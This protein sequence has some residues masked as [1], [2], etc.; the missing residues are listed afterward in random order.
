M[1][2]EPGGEVT[3]LLE[4]WREGQ[5]EAL[6]E[7]LPLVYEELR[8]LAAHY[9]G[10]ER[11]G[12]TLQATALVHEAYVRL[13]GKPLQ[14]EDRSHFFAVAARAMRRVLV[15]HARRHQADKRIGPQDKVSLE[16][17]PELSVQPDV[18]VL[19]LH[20]ALERLGQVN[21]RQAKLVEIRYFGGLKNRE[22]AE[23]LGVSL[24]TVERDWQVARL[25]LHRQLTGD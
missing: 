1:A 20:E 6:D 18:D 11:R 12:H 15:D 19:A 10:K 24:G 7:L 5:S 14:V 23:V 8:R 25:W 9:L 2:A 22:A 16:D 21:P 13:L 17:G 3:Q 4:R